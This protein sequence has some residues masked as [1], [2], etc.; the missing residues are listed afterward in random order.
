M[1]SSVDNT[2][3][4]YFPLWV[5]EQVST[6]KYY[7]DLDCTSQEEREMA[8][9]I[10]IVA[11]W[12]IQMKPCDRPPMNKVLKM[13]EGDFKLPMPPKPFVAPREGV[14]DRQ[15]TRT[16]SIDYVSINIADN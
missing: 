5:Y 11:L 10:I 7:L 6:G 8:M 9:K 4:I 1:N 12:C 3:Q 16:Y 15:I 2:N 14:E 13:L